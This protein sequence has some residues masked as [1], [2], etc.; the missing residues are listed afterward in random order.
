M[1]SMTHPHAVVRPAAAQDV[2]AIGQ[3]AEVAGLF[4]SSL[5]PGMIADHLAGSAEQV[6]RVVEHADKLSG[7]AFAEPERLADR[8]WNLRAIGVDPTDRRRGLA[9]SLLA[10]VEAA[11]R[12]RG[13]R[14]VLI[15]TTDSDDQEAS[16]ALYSARAYEEEARIRNF[17]EVG[18]G[19]VVFCKTL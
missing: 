7:F 15:E 1:R 5:L 12:A 13:G 4:P 19:K 11:L 6:W 17:W 3:L 2:H 14:L 18:V 16:R 10:D 9:T 8:T